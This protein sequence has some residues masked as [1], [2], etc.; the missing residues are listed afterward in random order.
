MAFT[1]ASNRAKSPVT[2]RAAA[3]DEDQFA[4]IWINVGVVTEEQV[5]DENGKPTT[6]EK[7]NRLP[8][9]IAVSDLV[10]HRLYANSAERNPE[11]AEEATLVNQIMDIVREQ[12]LTLAEGESA[13][14][15]LSV[16]LYRRQ[17][18]V[19][20]A[21]IPTADSADLKAKLFA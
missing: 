14:I 13:P 17:E 7:F 8:R 4:G 15:N 6:V 16:Q 10:D 9:G 12:G 20:A 18:Q 2:K 3:A 19:A 21:P 11:W 5:S 1:I